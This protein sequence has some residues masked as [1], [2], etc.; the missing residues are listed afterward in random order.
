MTSGAFA[1]FCSTII[2]NPIDV[3]K[4]KMQ[5]L[6]TTAKYGGVA[7]SFEAVYREQGA[8]GFLS[9]VQPRLCRVMT[10]RSLVFGLY[11]AINRKI[12]EYLNND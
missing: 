1:G 3:V 4:T 6:N 10:E 8:I 7:G 12:S 5:G 2:T 9:G 11:H